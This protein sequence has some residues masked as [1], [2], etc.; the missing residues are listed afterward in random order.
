LGTDVKTA[1]KAA[2]GPDRVTVSVST[3]LEKG[4]LRDMAKV[5]AKTANGGCLDL[6]RSSKQSGFVMSFLSHEPGQ[7]LIEADAWSVAKA[8][9]LTG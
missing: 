5:W 4:F 9:Q 7:A 2:F 8:Q 6:P 3:K 1:L